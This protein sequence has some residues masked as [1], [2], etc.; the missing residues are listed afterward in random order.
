MLH[1]S[2]RR[3]GNDSAFHSGAL[4]LCLLH[5]L[6]DFQAKADRGH[7]VEVESGI[8]GNMGEEGRESAAK[9]NDAEGTVD[10]YSGRRIARQDHLVHFPLDV[11]W[12]VS[13]R[14]VKRLRVR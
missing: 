3:G 4:P 12:A 1:A 5:Q 7:F 8:A 2:L 10:D 9:L 14:L 13:L 6:T 11:G